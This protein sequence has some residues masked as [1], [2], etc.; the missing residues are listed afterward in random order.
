MWGTVVMEKGRSRI[1]LYCMGCQMPERAWGIHGIKGCLSVQ[2]GTC[3]RRSESCG[4]K[5]ARAA[6]NIRSGRPRYGALKLG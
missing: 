3:E 5:L 2:A 1:A 6:W 4:P